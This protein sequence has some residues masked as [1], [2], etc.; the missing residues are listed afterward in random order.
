MTSRRWLWLPFFV[1][2][3]AFVALAAWQGVGTLKETLS[4]VGWKVAWLVPLFLFPLAMAT[5]SW[6]ALF[7]SSERP[8]WAKLTYA[9]WIGLSVNQLLPVGRV[10]GEVVRTRLVLGPARPG[11]AV[12]T[13]VIADK[14]AQVAS[15]SLFA[16][17][18]LAVLLFRAVG[19]QLFAAGALGIVFV[20]AAGV[21]FF[22]AQRRGG[23]QAAGRWMS[24]LLPESNRETW[25][26]RVEDTQARLSRIYPTVGFAISVVANVSFRLGIGI[27]VWLIFRFLGH[28]IDVDDALMMEGLNQMLRA[29]TFIIPGALGA[30]EGGFV[31]LGTLVGVPAPAALAASLC[32]RAREVLVGLPALVVWQIDEGFSRRRKSDDPD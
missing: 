20:S 14:T 19:S 30:Q 2:L 7:E 17:A 27:E 1:G 13:S 22:V 28:P 9:R 12:V 16:A 18:G 32:M 8:G 25:L 26:D 11:S 24:F 21:G 15:V 23:V 4:V 29:A 5:W 10:G 6:G 3:F 31:A